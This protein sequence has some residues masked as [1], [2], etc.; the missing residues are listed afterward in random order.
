MDAECKIYLTEYDICLLKSF[1]IN[2]SC[3]CAPVMRVLQDNSKSHIT[4]CTECHFK[5]YS[6]LESIQKAAWRACSSAKGVE[7]VTFQIG[8]QLLSLAVL[9]R[10]DRRP[11]TPGRP[12]TP[13]PSVELLCCLW[14]LQS[15]TANFRSNLQDSLKGRLWWETLVTW[16]NVEVLSVWLRCSFKWIPSAKHDAMWLIKYEKPYTDWEDQRL[17]LTSDYL[18]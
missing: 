12:Q 5:Q 4:G 14:L 11:T 7:S 15:Q 2:T 8:C 9:A 10:A 6:D 18:S 1:V 17:K 3:E 16:A 13:H